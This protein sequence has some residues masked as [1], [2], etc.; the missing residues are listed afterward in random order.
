MQNS[1]ATAPSRQATGYPAAR[2]A[3][4]PPAGAGASRPAAAR[5]ASEPFTKMPRHVR[6]QNYQDLP[7]SAFLTD[8]ALRTFDWWGRGEVW[9]GPEAIAAVYGQDLKTVK[10]NLC[11]L[12]KA[13]LWKR[14]L[15]G[16]GDGPM[17]C[18][19][20]RVR[21]D[22]RERQSRAGERCVAL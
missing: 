6:H 7:A 10:K 8:M 15:R 14:R 17:T 13:G 11:L 1:T 9:P 21:R 2:H 5:A 20:T 22:L 12:E 16:V 3:T 19:Q 4:A 18:A